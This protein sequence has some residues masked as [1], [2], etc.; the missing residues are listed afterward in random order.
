MRPKSA[1]Y[2]GNPATKPTADWQE[3]I[4]ALDKALQRP[5]GNPN[6]DEETGR[7]APSPIFDNVQDRSKA[8]TGTSESAALRRLRKDRPDLHA[9]VLAGELSA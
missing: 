2:G 6:R 4:D 1:W 8:P 5:S 7:L 9:R 3:V